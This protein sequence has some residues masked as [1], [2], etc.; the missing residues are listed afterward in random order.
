VG[1][2]AIP[3]ELL[4]CYYAAQNAKSK[5]ENEVSP[6]E[7]YQRQKLVSRSKA[8]KPSGTIINLSRNQE[9]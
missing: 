3:C 8:T 2:I 5:A 9:S 7:I 4:V 6:P 1:D